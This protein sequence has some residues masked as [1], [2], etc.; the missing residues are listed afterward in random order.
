MQIHFTLSTASDLSETA[1]HD[2]A[3]KLGVHPRGETLVYGP[4][5]RQAGQA[6]AKSLGLE[7]IELPEEMLTT[8]Y[9][10][11]LATKASGACWTPGI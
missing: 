4:I 8:K 6:I 2:A 3:Y 11:A 1:V 7:T 5:N 10:W 9:T